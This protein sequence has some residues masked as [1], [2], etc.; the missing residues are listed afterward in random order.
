MNATS[1]AFVRNRTETASEASVFK[2][3]ARY[4]FNIRDGKTLIEDPDGT[5]LPNLDAARV[6][7][8][9]AAR[10]ILAERLRADQI[11]DGQRF[12]IMDE[13]G[14]LLDVVK[15]RDAMRLLSSERPEL[16]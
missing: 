2:P 7:A 9:A 6:E 1:Y 3:M 13:H 15:F 4:F 12:E 5:D 14:T 16:P 8:L 11:V 10:D